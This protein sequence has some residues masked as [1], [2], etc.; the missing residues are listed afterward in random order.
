MNRVS[1]GEAQTS[2][3]YAVPATADLGSGN[4]SP[5]LIMDPSSGY[6][7]S[8]MDQDELVYPCKGCGRVCFTLPG[9][10]RAMPP[11][12]M[13]RPANDIILST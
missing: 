2:Y 13:H 7:E 4:P 9:C 10:L 1:R 11:P 12:D 8:P 3:R 5:L 6:P